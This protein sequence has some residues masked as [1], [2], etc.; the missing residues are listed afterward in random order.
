MVQTIP[1]FVRKKKS[2]EFGW[3]GKLR[4]IIQKQGVSFPEMENKW[5]GGP[6]HLNPHIDKMGLDC[7]RA[8]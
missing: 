7:T 8:D 4:G 2:W 3:V 1:N 6:Q 5:F